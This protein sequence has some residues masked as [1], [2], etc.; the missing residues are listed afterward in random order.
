MKIEMNSKYTSNGEP[1]RILC[2]DK[3][4]WYPVVGMIEKTG[5]ILYFTENGENSVFSNLNL[6]EVWKPQEGEWC[7]VWDYKTDYAILAKFIAIGKLRDF[8]VCTNG[9]WKYCAK[10]IGELPEHLK[11]T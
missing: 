9:N 4:E 1:I 6:V 2:T 8:F 3:P 10:F 7:W 5:D 11:G